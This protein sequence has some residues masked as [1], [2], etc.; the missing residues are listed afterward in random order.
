MYNK[1]IKQTGGIT[2]LAKALSEAWGNSQQQTELIGIASKLVD[3]QLSPVD[4]AIEII[5]IA[6]D[7]ANGVD[8][9]LSGYVDDPI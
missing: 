3:G 4:A 6:A 9:L 7:M 8:C 5:A 1:T 2:M